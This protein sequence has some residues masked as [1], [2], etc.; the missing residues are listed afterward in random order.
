MIDNIEIELFKKIIQE[1]R[2]NPDVLD[3]YSINQF[4]AKEKL[5]EH[6]ENLNILDNNSEIVIFGSWYGSIFIPGFKYVKRITLVDTDRAVINISKN[7]LFDHYKNVDFVCNDVFEWAEDSSRIK[8]TDLIINTSCEHMK[9]MK[10]L[11]ILSNLNCYF[12][13]QSNN[14]FNIPTHTNCVNN[15]D[16]FKE[17]LPYNANVMV[18]DEIKDERGT[19]FLVI[20]RFNEKSNL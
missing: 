19:R 7:R 9:S 4:N 12:A 1:S 14:M 15:I 2:H 20:G 16:E 8:K 18:E 3:S 10:E 6:V 17:Q 11:K 5:I 13:F